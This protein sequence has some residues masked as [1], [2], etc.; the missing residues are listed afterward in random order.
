MDIKLA[1]PE[2]G[3]I[4]PR[5]SINITGEQLIG[6]MQAYADAGHQETT[7][8][9]VHQTLTN[10]GADIGGTNDKVARLLISR[11]LKKLG[12]TSRKTIKGLVFNTTKGGDA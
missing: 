10:M 6:V 8:K 12:Y 11:H 5:P 4:P 2:Q 1:A 7:A 3:D 9:L